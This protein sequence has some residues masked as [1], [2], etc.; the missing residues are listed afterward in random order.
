[1]IKENVC[2]MY[3]KCSDLLPGN[4]HFFLFCLTDL[5]KWFNV[6][7][8]LSINA[9]TKPCKFWQQIVLK[10]ENIDFEYNKFIVKRIK[11]NKQMERLVL[12]GFQDVFNNQKWP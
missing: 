6:I 12:N 11:K 1:M 4:K 8:Y 7:L 3:Q 2:A 5:L 10:I 9:R